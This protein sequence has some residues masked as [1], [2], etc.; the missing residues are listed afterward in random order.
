MDKPGEEQGQ[1]RFER[2]Q[3]RPA[4]C[5]HA[6]QAQNEEHR[7]EHSAE[8]RH[9]DEAAKHRTAKPRFLSAAPERATEQGRD[10]RPQVEEAAGREGAGSGGRALDQRRSRAEEERRE[11]RLDN[12]AKDRS[13]FHPVDDC[14]QSG[15]SGNPALAGR[16]PF[17]LPPSQ[18]AFGVAHLL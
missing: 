2:E 18:T 17:L 11:E 9:D 16:T 6:P 14:P 1:G 7:G 10:G 5:I 12:T 4:R 8:Q 15:P 13:S 3:Q